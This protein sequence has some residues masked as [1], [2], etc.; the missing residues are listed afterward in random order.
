ML[1]I[2]IPVKELNNY[3]FES[4]SH[5]EDNIL[6]DYEIIVV[7]DSC[8]ENILRKYNIKFNQNS[9]INIL[10]NPSKGRINALNYGYTHT[11]ADIIKCVDSDDTILNEFFNKQYGDNKL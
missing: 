4:L 7:Y 6:Y 5:Y 11:K 2:V 1:S 10:S 8:T 3:L 9:S